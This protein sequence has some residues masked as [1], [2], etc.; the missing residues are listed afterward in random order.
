M[1]LETKA[2]A[3]YFAWLE[4]ESMDKQDL[5]KHQN[6][7]LNDYVVELERKF[8]EVMKGIHHLKAKKALMLGKLAGVADPYRYDVQLK[9]LCA[10]C[11][12]IGASLKCPYCNAV[13]Y[14]NRFCRENDW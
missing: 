10:H 2:K 7:I 8:E 3:K 6:M 9:L 11:G 14:C 13:V 1:V 12:S 5:L 4:K